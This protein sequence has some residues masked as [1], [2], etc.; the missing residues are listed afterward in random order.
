M[1][2]RQSIRVTQNG[3][4][5]V[6]RGGA[7]KIAADLVQLIDMGPL[8]VREMSDPHAVVTIPRGDL[9]LDRVTYHIQGIE[10]PHLPASM[11][12]WWPS[13]QR[14]VQS[15]ATQGVPHDHHD[16]VQEPAEADG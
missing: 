3:G 4:R 5:I 8:Y 15:I 13:I 9:G 11:N 6:A 10:V 14:T 1:S 16:P 12:D 2:I 7:S